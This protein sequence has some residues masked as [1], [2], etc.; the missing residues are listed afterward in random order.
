MPR[1]SWQRAY[2]VL[3]KHRGRLL[4]R[5]GVVAVDVGVRLRRGRPTKTPAIRIHV[6]E[7]LPK[8]ALAKTRRFPRALKGVP[9]DV[10]ETNL[11]PLRCPP[12]SGHLRVFRDPLIGGVAIAPSRQ[13]EFGTFGA[14]VRNPENINF[15]LTAQHVVNAETPVMV[16]PPQVAQ[17][18]GNVAAKVLDETMDAA[19]VR[20]EGRDSVSGI[21]GIGPIT[22]V[23]DPIPLT[24]LPLDVRI[25]GA[26]SGASE[27]FVT[28]RSF[29]IEIQY[30][31]GPVRF[32]NQLHL[33]GAVSGQEFSRGGDSGAI[34]LERHGS[35]AVGL[36]FAGESPGGSDFGV[37]TP[38]RSILK[39][40]GVE[41]AD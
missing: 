28:S 29:D 2:K 15:A 1:V 17:P 23:L 8:E 40:L 19:L 10:I 31:S 32:K 27:G 39:R 30:P 33:V 25:M 3:A 6:A 16:Q 11:A 5:A 34:V 38:I 37:A 35:R 18:I 12:S 36:L 13:R 4:R 7:K 14:M 24:A 9:V 22:G 21:D 41:F 20:L 26:C